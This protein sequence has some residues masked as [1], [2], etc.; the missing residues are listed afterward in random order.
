MIKDLKA[1]YPHSRAVVLAD[2]MDSLQRGSRWVLRDEDGPSCH[3]QGSGTRDARGNLH[4]RIGWSEP[5]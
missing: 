2:S 4:S 5:A 1:Q 3:H